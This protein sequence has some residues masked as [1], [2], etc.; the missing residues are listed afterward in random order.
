[1]MKISKITLGLFS[2][3]FVLFSLYKYFSQK[4]ITKEQ[5]SKIIKKISNLSIHFIF[6][7]YDSQNKI[8]MK[9]QIIFRKINIHNLKTLIV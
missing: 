4:R 6:Q 5:I 1:M 3:G 8:I 7:R 9:N 2:S